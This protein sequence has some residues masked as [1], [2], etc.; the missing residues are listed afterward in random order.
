[1]EAIRDQKI[2]GQSFVVDNVVFINCHLT[3]CD[4][5]YSGGDFE[6]TNST[7]DGCR[8]HWRGPARNTLALLQA[9]GLLKPPIKEQQQ[10]PLTA[11]KV[12]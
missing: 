1:M 12:N 9:L 8:F 4:F 11:G 6:W 3:D 2:S 5:F 7:F 10:I